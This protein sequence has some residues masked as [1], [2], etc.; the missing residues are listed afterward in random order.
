MLLLW[1]EIVTFSPWRARHT[2][3][4]PACLINSYG[5]AWRLEGDRFQQ[6][7]DLTPKTPKAIKLAMKTSFAICGICIIG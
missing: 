1:D 4:V 3:S 6:S 2:I 5:T 7:C